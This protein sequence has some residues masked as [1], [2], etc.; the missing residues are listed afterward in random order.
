M[1]R[2]DALDATL[3]RIDELAQSRD[4]ARSR[5]TARWDQPAVRP[6]AADHA[7]ARRPRRT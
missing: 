5:G 6:E 3:V 1:R 2:S 7:L 4:T